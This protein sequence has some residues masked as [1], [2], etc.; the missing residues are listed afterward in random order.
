MEIYVH[1][2]SPINNRFFVKME[3]KQLSV[4][5]MLLCAYSLSDGLE[6][7]TNPLRQPES[8]QPYMLNKTI[9]KRSEGAKNSELPNMESPDQPQ[10]L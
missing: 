3:W 7:E 9:N 8:S 10:L 4:F 1:P 6:T 5:V 2:S